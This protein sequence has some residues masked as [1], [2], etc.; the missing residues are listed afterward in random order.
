MELF[1]RRKNLNNEQLAQVLYS[2]GISGSG[3]KPFFDEMEIMVIDSPVFIE[4]EYLE[5]ISLG[6]T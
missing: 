2:F 3:Q 6:Y 4:T 5:K 1:K